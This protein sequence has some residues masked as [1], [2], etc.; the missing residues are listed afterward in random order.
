MS[1]DE[2]KIPYELQKHERRG[3]KKKEMLN[4]MPYRNGKDGGS[5]KTRYVD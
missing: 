2:L 3:P 1:W 5:N 4:K